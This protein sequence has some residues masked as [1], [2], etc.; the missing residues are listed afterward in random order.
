MQSLNK[1]ANINV[2]REIIDSKFLSLPS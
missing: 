1:K 2:T